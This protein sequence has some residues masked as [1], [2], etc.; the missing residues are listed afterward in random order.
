MVNPENH[1][2]CAGRDCQLVMSSVSLESMCK[3][4]LPSYPRNSTHCWSKQHFF[5]LAQP[6][7]LQV[8]ENV[9]GAVNKYLLSGAEHQDV[10]Q[11]YHS[12]AKK[13]FL[14]N[15]IYR[16]LECGLSVAKTE[17]YRRMVIVAP[18]RSTIEGRGAHCRHSEHFRIRGKECWF[19]TLMSFCF[20]Q[21][22]QRQ[23][24]PFFFVKKCHMEAPNRGVREEV[25]PI[26]QIVLEVLLKGWWLK[27]WPSRGAPRENLL[28]SGGVTGDNLSYNQSGERCFSI[29]HGKCAKQHFCNS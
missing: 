5:C 26:W 1:C 25:E 16:I 7:L 21:S 14:R 9:L 28:L 10:I 8:I 2:T 24:L 29:R 22:M 12:I 20:L 19:F 18:Y 6:A 4:V 23:R 13:K 17:W 3:S 15:S 27:F 11:V